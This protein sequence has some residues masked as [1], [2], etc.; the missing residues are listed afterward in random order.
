M[1]HYETCTIAHIPYESESLH[2]ILDLTVVTIMQFLQEL[3]FLF[4]NQTIDEKQI[5]DG[6]TSLLKKASALYL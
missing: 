1:K 5:D 2:N 4:D 3:L 6:S